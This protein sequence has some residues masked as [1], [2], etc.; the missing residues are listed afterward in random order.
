MFEFNKITILDQSAIDEIRKANIAWYYCE[1]GAPA[2]HPKS[3]MTEL[4]EDGYMDAL[5][6]FYKASIDKIE[7]LVGRHSFK[8]PLLGLPPYDRYSHGIPPIYLDGDDVK[9]DIEVDVTLDHLKLIMHMRACDWTKPARPSF[10]PKR[11]FNDHRSAVVGA[12]V[13]LTGEEARADE[14]GDFR[15][16]SEET[17]RFKRLWLET[18]PVLQVIVRHA[19]VKAG[20]YLSSFFGG[21]KRL[22][23]CDDYSHCREPYQKLVGKPLSRR[24]Y[25][26]ILRAR[27]DAEDRKKPKTKGS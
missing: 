12:Y 13:A 15:L 26:A 21:F 7:N 19:E 9:E 10:D 5:I 17:D 18:A 11:V 2:I 22:G 23:D 24:E 1:D 8:N 6:T 27:S 14:D 25:L 3:P 20:I 16:S 4:L